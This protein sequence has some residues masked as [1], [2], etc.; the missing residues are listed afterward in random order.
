MKKTHIINF[1]FKIHDGQFVCVEMNDGLFHAD[2]SRYDQI[3]SENSNAMA[4]VYRYLS[5]HYE[6]IYIYPS[7]T[8][9]A[10]WVEMHPDIS[11]GNTTILGDL[12]QFIVSA[13]SCL[14]NTDNTI[15]VA[16]DRVRLDDISSISPPELQSL[17]GRQGVGIPVISSNPVLR[18]CYN[19]PSFY[20]VFKSKPQ[21][22]PRTHYLSKSQLTEDIAKFIAVTDDTMFIIKPA[23]GSLAEGALVVRSIEDLLKISGVLVQLLDAPSQGL[24]QIVTEKL[25]DLQLSKSEQEAVYYLIVYLQRDP[26]AL[27]CIQNIVAPQDC[28]TGRVMVAITNDRATPLLM[29][30][31]RAQSNSTELSN[32]SLIQINSSESELVSDDTEVEI[33]NRGVER[34]FSNMAE[35]LNTPIMSFFE[36][37]MQLENIHLRNNIVQYLLILQCIPELS[38]ERINLLQQ[39]GNPFLST[40]LMFSLQYLAREDGLLPVYPDVPRWLDRD[41]NALNVNF[42]PALEALPERFGLL[43]KKIPAY[44]GNVIVNSISHHLNLKKNGAELEENDVKILHRFLKALMQL[45]TPHACVIDIHIQLCDYYKHHENHMRALNHGFCAQ[46]LI[47]L[48]KNKATG[49]NLSENMLFYSSFLPVEYEQTKASLEAIIKILRESRHLRYSPGLAYVVKI[50][51][52]QEQAIAE[53]QRAS[54][55]VEYSDDLSDRLPVIQAMHC[56]IGYMRGNCGEYTQR[57]FKSFNKRSSSSDEAFTSIYTEVIKK[58]E[59]A[60]YGVDHSLMTQLSKK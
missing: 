10:V 20:Q 18:A 6:H 54:M 30:W 56:L 15:L 3:V 29:Y 21:Q 2:Y 27:L 13:Q 59:D 12:N 57:M 43:L 34:I 42:L 26:A 46:T 7:S 36:R 32:E 39:N 9:L 14:I 47:S 25:S 8:P 45:S 53:L 58:F 50:L 37:N 23:S 19:K 1:D 48:T 60:I 44:L 31:R 35:I 16:H 51:I 55:L 11:Q 5:E 33:I 22:L 49:A 41:D 38:I 24:K 17:L 52:S 28:R 40:L 4:V